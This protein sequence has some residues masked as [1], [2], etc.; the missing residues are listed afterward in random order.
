[1]V[2]A[3]PAIRSGRDTLVAARVG[4]FGKRG[5]RLGW[6]NVWAQM[7]RVG[8]RS[9]GIVSL[10]LLCATMGST[11]QIETQGEDED[12]AL[13]AVQQVFTSIE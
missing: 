7:N 13:Q 2:Q 5:R 8:V 10:V 1:M 11:L 9:I 12:R 4:L 3:W 6:T